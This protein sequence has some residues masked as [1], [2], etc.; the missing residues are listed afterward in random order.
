[1]R[2][3]GLVMKADSHMVQQQIRPDWTQVFTY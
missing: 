1:M 2:L 3:S